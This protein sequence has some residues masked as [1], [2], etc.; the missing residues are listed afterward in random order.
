MT[1]PV[2]CAPARS[3]RDYEREYLASDFEAVQARMRKRMLL[4]LLQKVRAR[5]ILEVGCGTESMFSHW[6]RFDRFVIVE[7][8]P[9]FA[10]RARSGAGNDTRISVVEDF[11]ETAG[12]GLEGERFDVILVSGLLHEVPDPVEVLRVV[13]AL[14]HQET[15]VHANVP[16]ARSLHRLL[17]L[18]MGLIRDLHEISE[19]QLALSQPRTFDLSMLRAL[20]ARCGFDEIASGSYFVK[21]FSH[22]QMAQLHNAGMVNERMLHGLNGLERHLPGL[23]SEI[24]INLRRA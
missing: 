3:I 23:G 10:A 16:N 20:C 17:A 11:I 1:F 2:A 24:F 6:R 13:R 8:G 5:R 9:E 21:P 7:P 14:C 4:S 19:R 22:S 12:R 18:E 15:L